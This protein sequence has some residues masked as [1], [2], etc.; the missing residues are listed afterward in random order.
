MS[1]IAFAVRVCTVRALLGQTLAGNAVEDAP[2]DPIPVGKLP[3]PYIAVFTDTESNRP[4]ARS[5]IEGDHVQDLV[6]HIILPAELKLTVDGQVYDFS[7]QQSGAAL[8]IDLIYRQVEN[9]LMAGQSVWSNLWRAFVLKFD[10]V[11]ARAYVLQTGTE[12]GVRVPAREIVLRC[13]TLFSPP[14]GNVPEGPW[15]DL[16]AALSADPETQGF[17]PLLAGAI[18]GENLPRWRRDEAELGLA[19]SEMLGLGLGP[20]GGQQTDDE[21]LNTEVTFTEAGQLDPPFT[22]DNGV[23]EY[24]A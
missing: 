13:S 15:A 16:I 23:P 22:I 6:L 20:L 2:V 11:D 3:Q 19:N 7:A 24:G 4:D 21:V 5:M 14:L 10:E 12:S 8:V 1:L 17:A 18:T 9:V